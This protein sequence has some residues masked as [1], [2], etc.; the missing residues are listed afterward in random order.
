MS[1]G[2]VALVVNPMASRADPGA[3][4]EAVAILER[5]DLVHV[6]LTASREDGAG[7]TREAV[8]AG[9]RLVVVMG[10]DGTVGEVA[11]ALVGRDVALV[12]IAAGSTNV[13]ARTVGWPAGPDAGLRALEVALA[14]PRPRELRLGRIVAGPHDRA[15]CVSAGVGLDAEAVHIVEARPAVKRRIRQGAF[16]G[17][18]TLAALRLARNPVT[19][20]LVADG[21]EAHE[22]VSAVVAAGS[23]YTY[24]G[25][26]AL[27]LV[28]GASFD[29]V[30]GWTGL[31]R[32]PLHETAAVLAGALRGGRHVERDA[33]TSG[34]AREAVEV[35][36]EAPV[37]M[38]VDGEPLGWHERARIMPGGTVILLRPPGA[39]RGVGT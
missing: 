24:L 16:V 12:P 30:L 7:L 25:R 37:A 10:G 8:E 6:G 3:R 14:H 26:R 20:S 28:P 32:A 17:G 29:G 18:V 15:F 21:G 22:L 23:P 27:D 35:A 11:G 19:L 1:A 34:E 36:A 38:Q 39:T 33:V 31:R 13:F 4:S 5:H 2:P 9:A